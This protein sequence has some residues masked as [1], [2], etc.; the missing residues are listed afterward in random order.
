LRGKC[1]SQFSIIGSAPS[2]IRCSR[3]L[4]GTAG[5]STNHPGRAGYRF[6]TDTG[7]STSRTRTALQ[8]SRTAY[9]GTWSWWWPQ[10]NCSATPRA[11]QS[12][13]GNQTQ[14]HQHVMRGA[15][16]LDCSHDPPA[17]YAAVEWFQSK[18]GESCG[19]RCVEL[20]RV[21]FHQDSPYS[22]HVPGDGCSRNRSALERGRPRSPLGIL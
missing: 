22:S 19:C 18:T 12:S 20:F 17:L 5:N 15:P 13:V 8:S 14:T 11:R 4:R 3:R 10:A 7:S 1:S 21:Q 16:E 6:A 9:S 2:P